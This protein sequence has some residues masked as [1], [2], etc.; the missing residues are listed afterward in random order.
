[1]TTPPDDLPAELKSVEATLQNRFKD[2][3]VV[4]TDGSEVWCLNSTN[5]AGIGLGRYSQMRAEQ[6]LMKA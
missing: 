6:E 4:A 1:M 5:T 2:Y 3:L